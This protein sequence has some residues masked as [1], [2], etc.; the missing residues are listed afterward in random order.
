MGRLSKH[1]HSPPLQ[2]KKGITFGLPLQLD[3]LFH[4]KCSLASVKLHQQFLFAFN[5]PVIPM[6]MR[7]LRKKEK[8]KKKTL[9]GKI[10]HF[11]Q[12]QLGSFISREVFLL[13]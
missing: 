13:L 7:P 10:Q 5:T 1:P 9:K 3:S 2:K 8:E 6:Q 11:P 4:L 12:A